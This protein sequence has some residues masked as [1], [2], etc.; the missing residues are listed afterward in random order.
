MTAWARRPS[1][2]RSHCTWLP[3]PGGAFS[4]LTSKTPPIVSLR[5]FARSISPIICSAAS[6]SAQRTGDPSA[7]SRSSS[8]ER[9]ATS[10]STCPMR[11]TW[12]STRT[13]NSARNARA[14]APT[15]TRMVVSRALARSRMSRRSRRSYFKPP[16]RSACPGRG[17]VTWRLTGPSAS[18]M[19]ITSVQFFQSWFRT[20]RD[21]GPPMVL[22][23][24]TPPRISI[25]SVSI[26][27]LRPRP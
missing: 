3:R 17:R 9:P 21:T 6:A 18:S 24:R 16:A 8:F 7:R 20:T 10:A 12:L 23:W 2:L 22:P 27:I 4:T 15:A 14:T 1:S 13:S 25:V 19:A 11:T 26:C 5:D